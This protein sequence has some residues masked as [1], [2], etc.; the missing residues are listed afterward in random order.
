MK[1][2]AGAAFQSRAVPHYRAA[3]P[4][5]HTHANIL[6]DRD[7]PVICINPMLDPGLSHAIYQSGGVYQAPKGVTT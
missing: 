5:S 1:R 4:R 2:A 3:D 7:M 6:L